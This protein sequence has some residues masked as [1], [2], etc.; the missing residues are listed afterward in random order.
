MMVWKKK[1]PIDF[2]LRF[3]SSAFSFGVAEAQNIE[4]IIILRFLAGVC[5][6]S[7]LNNVPSSLN[8]VRG[9]HCAL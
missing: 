3:S 5:G 6:S 9:L 2:L 1:T 4:T 8:D 7:A